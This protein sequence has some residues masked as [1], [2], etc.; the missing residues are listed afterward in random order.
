MKKSLDSGALALMALLA[1]PSFAPCQVEQGSITGTVIDSSGAAVSGVSVAL[2]AA[3]TQNRWNSRT[4]NTG[5]YTVPYLPTGAY[6]VTFEK[7]GFAT[8]VTKGVVITVGLT[9]TVDATLVPGS[10]RQEI[11]VAAVAVELEQQTSDVGAVV[12]GKNARELPVL[13]RNAFTL[14]LMA[15]GVV[16]GNNAANP[17][18]ASVT[19]G[20]TSSMDMLL[21]GSEIRNSIGSGAMYTPPLEAVGEFKV[22]TNNFSAEFGRS[23][24][25]VITASTRAGTIAYHGALYE[26]LQNEAFNANGWINDRSGLPKTKYRHNEYGG[27]IGGPLEIPKLYSGHDKTFFFFNWEQI[28]QDTPLSIIGTVPTQAERNGDFSQ[29]RTAT[30]Q[31][32]TIYDPNTTV[33][34]PASAGQYIRSV[35]PGNIIPASRIS[36]IIANAIA[37]YPLQNRT[38]V[39]NNFAANTT[40]TVDTTR[41]ILRLDHRFG[42]RQHLMFTHGQDDGNTL[43]PGISIAFPSETSNNAAFSPS[44]GHSTS[45]SDTFVFSPTFIGE[46]RG[47]FGRLVLLGNPASLGFDYTKLGFPASLKAQSAALLFPYFN[48][49]DAST[50]GVASNAYSNNTQQNIGATA[51]FTWIKGD[52][53]LKFGADLQFGEMNNFRT[54]YPSGS[55]NFTRAYTQGPNPATATVT[56]GDGIATFLLGLPTGG[57]F[58][59]DPSLAV[60]QKSPAAFIQ[61]DWKI[62]RNLTLNIGVRYDYATPWKERYSRLAYFDRAAPDPVTHLPGSLELLGQTGGSQVDAKATNLAPRFGFAWTPL[63]K[64]VIRGGGGF[65]WFP[66]NGAISAS[67]TAL[68]DGYYVS[69]ALYLGPNAAAPNTPPAGASLANP[70]VSGIVQPPSYLVGSAISTRTRDNPTP[71]SMQ[72][73]FGIQRALPKQFLAEVTYL[74]NRGQHLWNTLNINAVNPTYLSLG[75]GLDQLVSNPFHKTIG[76]GTLS[77]ATVAQSQLLRPFPQYLDVTD[78]GYASGDSIYHALSARIHREF[79]GGFFVQFSYTFSKN[80]NDAPESFAAQSSVLNPYDLRQ[81]RSVA[82]WDRTNNVASNWVWALPFGPGQRFANKGFTS[83]VI[84]N[85]QLSGT[86]T[87]ATGIPVKITAPSNSRLPGVT[88]SAVR[89]KDPNLPSGQ[90]TLDHWFDTTAFTTAPLYSLG[91]DSRNEPTLR[92]PGLSNVN[93]AVART[94]LVTERIRLQLRGEFFNA[95]NSPPYGPPNGN[96]TATNFGQVS[97]VTTANP[98]RTVQLGA[99]LTF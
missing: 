10:V 42:S 69:T 64:T 65:F 23:G 8:V 9:A 66:G 20:R 36:P 38:S 24:G 19:G 91:N 35:F 94:Q 50:I 70:F 46:F 30:G 80:I 63:P 56:G 53:T 47:T 28:K 41:F 25:G 88:G 2:V 13:G 98:G 15:P 61:D 85:W 59:V 75:A 7:D 43:R 62:R 57:S 3:E 74:G 45:I 16:L 54:Q 95:L 26:F 40:S 48:V 49:T 73:N 58:S 77:S 81:S 67:P 93:A 29:S 33:A 5:T 17:I 84:G 72:W 22:I 1:A 4:N 12:E 79:R 68:G 55:Y 76:N 82:D 37:Y 21:D 18:T 31:L 92:A 32:L 96:L 44:D 51:H 90:Q 27:A 97:T 52:N 78:T 11:T 87:L 89:L 71:L 60:I 83:R 14:V 86:V 34:N 39:A 6:D 99:R